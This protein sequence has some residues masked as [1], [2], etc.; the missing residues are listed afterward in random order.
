MFDPFMSVEAL[1]LTTLIY[2]GNNLAEVP[3][4]YQMEGGGALFVNIT[5]RAYRCLLLPFYYK[6]Q[7]VIFK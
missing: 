3:A 6:N 1:E 7:P 4:V 2:K 5:R